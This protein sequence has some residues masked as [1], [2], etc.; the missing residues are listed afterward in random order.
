VNKFSGY[1]RV[2][3]RLD[4]EAL[5]NLRYEELCNAEGFTAQRSAVS[6]SESDDRNLLLGAFLDCGKLIST[7]RVEIITDANDLQRKLDFDGLDKFLD[8]PVGLLGKAAT[9]RLFRSLGL[10]TYLR[11]MA[12]DFLHHKVKHVVGTVLPDALRVKMMKDLGYRFLKNKVGWHRYG[13]KSEGETLI[14]YLDL[15]KNYESI[16]SQLA[17]RNQTLKQ[18]FKYLDKY[19]APLA[20]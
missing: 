8:V 17:L 12:Y 10:H 5:E 18:D 16:K 15:E 4:R 14:A 3:D 6:W 19:E 7:M 9:H 11:E 2:L 1:V 20:L 13:Y